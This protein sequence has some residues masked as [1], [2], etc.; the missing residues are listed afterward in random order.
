MSTTAHVRRPIVPAAV[1]ARNLQRRGSGKRA[2][3]LTPNRERLMA[4]LAVWMVAVGG[5]AFFIP[6]LV[7]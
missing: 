5:A 6:H 1:T 7:A 2:S 4:R 3:W